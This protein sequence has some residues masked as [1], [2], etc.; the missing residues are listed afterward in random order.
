MSYTITSTKC[1]EYEVDTCRMAISKLIADLGGIEKFVSAGD[2]ILLKLNLL[3]GHKPELAATTHPIIVKAV[4]QIVQ[5]AGGI[6]FMGDS[7]GGMVTESVYQ[8]ILATTG[9]AQIADETG[10]NIVFFDA[11]QVNYTSKAARKFKQF[12]IVH[13]VLDFD[14]VIALPKLK[15]HQFTGLTCG[16][17]LLYGYLPGITKAENHLHAGKNVDTFSELLLDIFESFPPMLTIADAITAMQGNGPAH[18]E[19]VATNLLFASTSATAIDWAACRITG[20]APEA[21]ATVRIAGQRDIG[22]KCDEDVTWIGLTPDELRFPHFKTADSMSTTAFPAWFMSLSGYLFT[23]RP[24]IT[25]KC[26]SCGICYKHCPPHAM[27]MDTGKP[28]VINYNKCIRCYCCQELCP[29]NAV[30]V[31]PPRVKL[32]MDFAESVIKI[33]R[34]LKGNKKT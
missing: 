23:P 30:K 6:V 12:P 14:K 3:A 8:Q 2:R 15:T 18:G 25:A 1:N 24:Q 32:N 20:M 7:P 33:A 10:A 34:K 21:I 26:K 16:V 13:A 11:K 27:A 4:V 22:P 29:H 9:I 19:P 17:K 5:D 31:L 28:P